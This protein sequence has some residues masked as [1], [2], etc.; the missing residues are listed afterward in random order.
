LA[1]QGISTEVEPGAKDVA[2]LIRQ[3]QH[4][5]IKAVFL[6][7][8]SNPKLIG[9]IAKDTGVTMG[10]ALFV[11]ALSKASADGGSYLKLM[12]HNVSSLVVG[13]AKN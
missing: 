6:E 12:R 8:M 10:P 2:K 9:Q 3:I 1:P 11:D 5:K 7:N 13:M 4:E